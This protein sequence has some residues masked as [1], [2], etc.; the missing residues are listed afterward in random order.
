MTVAPRVDVPLLNEFDLGTVRSFQS[1]LGIFSVEDVRC[2]RIRA[3][4][5]PVRLNRVSQF[6]GNQNEFIV[7]DIVV[8]ES[9][10][11]TLPSEGVLEDTLLV[12]NQILFG[13]PFS[14]RND[15]R[16]RGALVEMAADR[17][18]IL[19]QTLVA[20]SRGARIL[21]GSVRPEHINSTPPNPMN[22]RIVFD[23]ASIEEVMALLGPDSIGP[24]RVIADTE[25][26]MEAWRLRFGA[27][28]PIEPGEVKPVNLD[29]TQTDGFKRVLGVPETP[30]PNTIDPE[31]LDVEDEAGDIDPEKQGGFRRRMEAAPAVGADDFTPRY[32]KLTPTLSAV[33]RTG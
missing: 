13:Q 33:L 26:Q 20:I 25:A 30:G 8:G 19:A 22:F 2:D 16:Y 9:L 31:D 32:G 5:A 29:P 12:S 6:S 3:G 4:S 7:S 10:T 14:F 18:A 11:I 23:C 17:I 21:P 24:D 15:G 1:D 27:R 28:G